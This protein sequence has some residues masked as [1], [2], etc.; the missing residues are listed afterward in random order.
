MLGFL[1][2]LISP[3]A[4]G[5]EKPASATPPAQKA[6]EPAAAAP[7]IAIKRS[8]D[9][10]YTELLRAMW[11]EGFVAPNDIEFT[12][13]ITSPLALNS[14]K[15]VL[16]LA[17]GMGGEA[18]ALVTLYKTYVTAFER[19][20]AF[21][22]EGQR[23]STRAGMVRTA[24]V[25]HYDPEAFDFKKSMDV[26]IARDLLYTL[27]DKKAFIGRITG[28][29]KPRGH[30]VLTDFVCEADAAENPLIGDWWKLEPYGAYPAAVGDITS[31]L[32]SNGFD[33]RVSED[34]TERYIKMA[35]AGLARLPAL[36]QGRKGDAELK[37]LIIRELD[38]WT[39]RLAALKGP[40]KHVRFHAIK[41]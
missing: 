13:T 2:K 18:R 12:K 40:L 15:S 4:K 25:N 39:V 16:D 7:V 32:E 1:N 9:E 22:A 3:A 34:T 20:A 10:I 5:K 6:P 8:T 23:L 17:A 29:L 31:L 37:V 19:N 30:L 11:G 38:F 28:H 27:A 35:L 36:L 24:P 21:A 41:K 14:Q 26:I 33:V